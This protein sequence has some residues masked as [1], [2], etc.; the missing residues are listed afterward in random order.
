VLVVDLCR[1]RDH[2]EEVA[3]ALVNDRSCAAVAISGMLRLT[4]ERRRD[5]W[6]VE[7]NRLRAG[8]G[9]L[10]RVLVQA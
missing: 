2:A 8:R 1:H 7:T 4:G 3:A 9:R 10:V 6:L 5:V